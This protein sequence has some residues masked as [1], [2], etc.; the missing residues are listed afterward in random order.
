MTSQTIATKG[1]SKLTHV[2]IKNAG[3]NLFMVSPEVTKTI[4]LFLSNKE[5]KTESITINL[6]K[7]I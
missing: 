5:I 4:K 1:L 7:L 2:T 3:H 6:P